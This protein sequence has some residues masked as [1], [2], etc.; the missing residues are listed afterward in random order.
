V[1]TVGRLSTIALTVIIAAAALVAGGRAVTLA[2][3]SGAAAPVAPRESVSPRVPPSA[4]RRDADQ[5]SASDQA[6]RQKTF[7]WLLLLLKEH[8]GAR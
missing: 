1:H 7:A 2:P 4:P 6:E 5:H 3:E 8:R